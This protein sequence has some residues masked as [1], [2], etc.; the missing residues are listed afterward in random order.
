[1]VVLVKHDMGCPMLGRPH[2]DAAKR[3][4]DTYH[5]HRTADRYGAVGKWFAAALNDGSTD[6]VLYDSRKAAIL[7]Q[8]HDEMYYTYVQV[9]HSNMTLCNAASLLTVARRMYDAGLRITD[10]D[11]SRREPIKRLTVEDQNAF[12]T[13]GIATGLEWPSR[14]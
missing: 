10:P 9:T 5:L 14:N 8:H 1:M 7:H 13:K 12:V 2:D 11:D 6:G 3:V 4:Y